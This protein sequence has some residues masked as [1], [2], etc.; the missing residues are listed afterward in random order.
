VKGAFTAGGLD[1]VTSLTVGELLSRRCPEVDE[2][3]EV[4]P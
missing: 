4:C 3:V 1:E 2:L